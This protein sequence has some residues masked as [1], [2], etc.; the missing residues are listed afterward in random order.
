MASRIAGMAAWIRLPVWTTVP[1]SRAESTSSARE[2][3]SRTSSLGVRCPLSTFFS[4][5]TET[6]A[7]AESSCWV[8]RR[9]RRAAAMRAPTPSAGGNAMTGLRS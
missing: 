9:L 6:A 5:L 4:M 8:S 7:C 2:M 3:A 1:S